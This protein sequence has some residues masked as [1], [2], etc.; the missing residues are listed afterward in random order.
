MTQ[1]TDD[2]WERVQEA[3]LKGGLRECINNLLTSRVPLN[4]ENRRLIEQA[5]DDGDGN[6][7]SLTMT[8]DP[9]WFAGMYEDQEVMLG[10]EH[11]G[12]LFSV[13]HASGGATV[14]VVVGYGL[15]RNEIGVVFP[16]VVGAK[17]YVKGLTA[18]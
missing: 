4:I 15:I 3:L 5:Y 13:V 14:S 9:P 8:G 18:T 16:D 7:I 11:N 10:L 2:E 6:G 17:E 1:M 12:T